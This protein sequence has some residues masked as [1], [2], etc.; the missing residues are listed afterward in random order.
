MPHKRLKPEYNF[1]EDQLRSL[2]QFVPE[3]F[4]DGQINWETLKVALGEYLEDDSP[5]SEHFGLFWPGKRQ[6]RRLA[7]I[8]SK[9]TLVP[10]Y[11]EGLKA[12]GTPDKDGIN[13]S[14]NIFIEGEN[15]EVLK[16]LQKS[17]VGRIKMIY[18]DPP[19]NTGNDFIYE[20]D[21]TEPLR[22]YLRRT[23]QVDEE[24]RPLTTNTRAD[25]RF[26]SKWLSMIYPR[27][28]LAKN[29]LRDDGIIFISIDDSEN[30]HLRTVLNEVFGEENFVT[31]I[32]WNS[33]KSVTNTAIVSENHSYIIVFCK[34]ID[35]LIQNR[36]QFRLPEDDFEGFSNPDN[37]PR[38]P[39]KADPFQVGGWRPNQQYEITNP[40]TGQ[41]YIPNTGCSW[42]NDKEKFDELLKDNRIVFG[43]TGEAGPQRKR[44]LDEAVERGK[45]AKSLW[46]EIGTTTNGTQELKDI[47]DNKILFTN[48]KPVSLLKKEII[49]ASRNI[50][51][52][53]ILDFFAGSGTTAHA[54]L[55]LNKE[56]HGTRRFI[57][58]QMPEPCDENSEAFKA[59]YSNIAEI[60]KERIRRVVKKLRNDTGDSKNKK[61]QKIDF[62]EDPSIKNS[63]YGFKVFKLQES[64]YKI[65]KNYPG[66]DIKELENLFDNSQSP[67]AD[68]WKPEKLLAEI[69]L[70]EGFPLDSK[71]EQVTGIKKNKVIKV[72][73]DFHE[74]SLIFCLDSEMAGD[75]IKQLNLTG[76]DIFICL[77][78]AV[79]DQDKVRLA[80]KGMIKTI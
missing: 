33:T 46:D 26:H 56:D 8:P 80:D 21:F 31:T 55:E 16:I 76:D 35:W 10:V 61:Q 39:W 18:I 38:G 40:N 11:G 63:D 41:T 25:G 64:N 69:L 13:D 47:F 70:I 17:Y 5:D 54:V 59:G 71:L 77:D 24:G 12:D 42:K 30:N 14:H 4:A 62:Q 27:L 57:M 29:L 79:T 22:E 65:W 20:D 73:S 28:R 36:K 45:V 78:N 51:D 37:D 32:C 48:P 9:G 72:T 52:A 2:K 58:V 1:Y 75:T 3:A 66:T 67:L 53:I 15:L 60:A 7:G 50:K 49:L 44:F 43:S 23:G 68:N 6:A 19:Y 74:H 34:N